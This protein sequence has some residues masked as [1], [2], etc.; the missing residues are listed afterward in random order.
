MDL[1]QLNNQ[2]YDQLQRLNSD[3][4]GE[5]LKQAINRAK[6]MAGVATVIVNNGNL[7]VKAVALKAKSG[8]VDGE[9]NKLIGG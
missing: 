8:L 7:M 4:T 5:D 2:L 9:V 1:K 3:L 6:A